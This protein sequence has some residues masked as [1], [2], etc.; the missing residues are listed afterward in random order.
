MSK[1]FISLL[2]I[3]VV[4]LNTSANEFEIKHYSINDGLS[5]S[6]VN[7]VYQDSKGFIWIGTVKT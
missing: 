6:V 4:S 2:F 1:N 7:C 5:Q 3:F